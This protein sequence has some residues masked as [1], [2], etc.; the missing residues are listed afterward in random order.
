M[1]T[2]KIRRELVHILVNEPEFRKELRELVAKMARS[3]CKNYLAAR[4]EEA[5]LPFF[6]D[7]PVKTNRETEST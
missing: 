6:P 5:G 1:F 3:E 7:A 2:R 4:A